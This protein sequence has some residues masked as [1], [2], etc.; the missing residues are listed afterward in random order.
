M[1]MNNNF[2]VLLLNIKHSQLI[3][4]KFLLQ[5]NN[6]LYRAILNLLWNNGYILCYNIISNKLKIILKHLN[7]KSIIKSIKL[8]SKPSRYI[9][10]S[11][12][13]LWLINSSYFFILSTSSGLKSLV[14]CRID[15]IGGKLLIVIC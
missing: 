14:D 2:Y 4:R 3:N 13:Q 1:N 6:K 5:K 8:L 12:R 15:N 11:T 7:I 10:F 9:Y